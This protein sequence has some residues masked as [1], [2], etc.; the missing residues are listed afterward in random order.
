MSAIPS[1]IIER[2]DVL[3]DIA[4]ATVQC[5]P[6]PGTSLSHLRWMLNELRGEMEITKANRW[7]GFI[8]GTMIAAGLL[9]VTREREFTRPY[10]SRGAASVP[11]A[12]NDNM[13][14]ARRAA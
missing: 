2:Y 11:V 8:Q 14:G 1:V 12:A 5:E 6:E 10:L 7:L 13:A 3:L 4:G 9:T